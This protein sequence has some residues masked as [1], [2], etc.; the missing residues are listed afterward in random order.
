M[1]LVCSSIQIKSVLR[2]KVLIFGYLSSAHTIYVSKAVR[3]RGYFSKE[4]G[5]CVKKKFGENWAN[6]L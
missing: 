2:C 1:L 6:V 4:K 3:I 5:V